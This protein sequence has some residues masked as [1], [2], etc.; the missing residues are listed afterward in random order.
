M[1]VLILDDATVLAAGEIVHFSI[2]LYFIL[3]S[4]SYFCSE[5]NSMNVSFDAEKE[6][7]LVSEHH[8][9]GSDYKLR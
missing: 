2:R 5:Q 9:D 6:M 1:R 4:F 7:C 3:F 8:S